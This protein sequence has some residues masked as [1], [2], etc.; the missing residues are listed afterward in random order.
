MRSSD[1]DDALDRNGNSC[2]NQSQA[3]DDSRNRLCLTVS[4]RMIL[5][6]R[7]DCQPKPQRDDGRTHNVA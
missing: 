7:L 1:F 4:V 5:A 2:C 6:R 3:H